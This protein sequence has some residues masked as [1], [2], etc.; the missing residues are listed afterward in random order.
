MKIELRFHQCPNAY[1]DPD[2]AVTI[3]YCKLVNGENPLCPVMSHIAQLIL[4]GVL[5]KTADSGCINATEFEAEGW[6]FISAP[7]F[8]PKGYLPI[9]EKSQS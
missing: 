7:T 5:Q 9:F 4:K 3:A 2:H 6:P 1:W 8:I